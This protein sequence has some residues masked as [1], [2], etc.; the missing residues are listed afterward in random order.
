MLNFSSTLS[1]ERCSSLNSSNYGLW[2]TL[3]CDQW[4]LK[5]CL[6]YQSSSASVWSLFGLTDWRLANDSRQ[7]A[8]YL[9]FS[10]W[11]MR[12]GQFYMLQWQ[13]YSGHVQ[14][15]QF[16]AA[17]H[18]LII[19]VWLWISTGLYS[20]TVSQ[21]RAYIATFDYSISRPDVIEAVDSRTIHCEFICSTSKISVLEYTTAHH[22]RLALYGFH[23]G[24]HLNLLSTDLNT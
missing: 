8:L 15:R 5:R 13:W 22:R 4:Y 2:N 7:G 16:W 18:C 19:V 17:I 20:T 14:Q 23:S 3:R 9:S 10:Y 1:F 24:R 11:W 21:R 6:H 12:T